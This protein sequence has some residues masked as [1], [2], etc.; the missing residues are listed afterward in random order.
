MLVGVTTIGLLTQLDHVKAPY[1]H[2]HYGPAL[3]IYIVV[4][5]LGF[6]LSLVVKFKNQYAI[7]M[8][9]DIIE[10]TQFS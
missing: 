3:V 6:V 1:M 7:P 4:L 9:V 8:Q 10:L 5:V 2:E